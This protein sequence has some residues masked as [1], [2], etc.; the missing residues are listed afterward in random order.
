M[1]HS[2]SPVAIQSLL[3]HHSFWKACQTPNPTPCALLATCA[4]PAIILITQY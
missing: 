4:S 2:L 1:S 3:K